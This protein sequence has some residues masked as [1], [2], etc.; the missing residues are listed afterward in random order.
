MSTVFDAV[1]AERELT[2][3]PRKMEYPMT[4]RVEDAAI[5]NPWQRV[6]QAR[7]DTKT[8]QKAATR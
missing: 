1:K 2:P 5:K 4:D 8:A 6:L 3:V 7:Y